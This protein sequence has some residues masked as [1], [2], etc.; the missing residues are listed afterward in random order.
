MSETVLNE[1]IYTIHPG[2]VGVHAKGKRKTRS[3]AINRGTSQVFRNSEATSALYP[4]R[5]DKFSRSSVRGG[6][7]GEGLECVRVFHR[8]R[9]AKTDP[10]ERRSYRLELISQDHG[11]LVGSIRIFFVV[12]PTTSTPTRRL[13]SYC[14]LRGSR[15]VGTSLHRALE[16]RDPTSFAT[17]ASH[18]VRGA[19]TA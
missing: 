8:H 5:N 16:E 2:C 10:G 13:Y 15:D 12:S 17:S 11:T 1:A 3:G 9:R 7:R 6:C 19:C 4:A 14:T 18:N